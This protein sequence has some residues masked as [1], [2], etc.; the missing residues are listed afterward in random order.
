[1]ASEIPSWLP[2]EQQS[3]PCSYQR[4]SF[5]SPTSTSHHLSSPKFPFQHLVQHL[6]IST[7]VL[8][9]VRF[10]PHSGL[11]PVKLRLSYL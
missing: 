11:L 4:R 8:V 5:F 6:G 9:L 3:L 1:M 10:E 7:F 2:D